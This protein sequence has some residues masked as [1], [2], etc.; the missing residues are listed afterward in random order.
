ML[1]GPAR[2]YT[3]RG[4]YR[5]FIL[6]VTADN[7]D[8]IM[9]A[10]VGIQPDRTLDLVVELVRYNLMNVMSKYQTTLQL[11]PPG[12]PPLAP[13]IPTELLGP[14][15]DDAQSN[16]MDVDLRSPQITVKDARKRPNSPSFDDYD[17]QR[18]V[19][20]SYAGPNKTPRHSYSHQYS[21]GHSP[22]HAS[23][24]YSGGHANTDSRGLTRRQSNPMDTAPPLY[25]FPP[26]LPLLRQSPRPV[27]PAGPMHS[28]RPEPSDSESVSPEPDEEFIAAVDHLLQE[29][30]AW[31]AFYKAKAGNKVADVLKQYEFVTKKCKELRGKT[32]KGFQQH[33][34]DVCLAF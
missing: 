1:A 26:P 14:S 10:N 2:A 3:L 7:Q 6:R 22:R 4:K 28:L 31:T 32:L 27:S 33:I 8:E 13:K 18:A 24:H 15:Y 9:S 11:P 34:A 23:P 17:S 25:T 19:P 21:P 5:Q 20:Q 29:D 12:G 30:S 16:S